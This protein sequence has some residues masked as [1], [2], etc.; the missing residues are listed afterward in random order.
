M[1]VSHILASLDYRQGGPPQVARN[2]G[3][4]MTP[5]GV[6]SSFWATGEPSDRLLLDPATECVNLFPVVWPRSWCRSPALAARLRL[7]LPQIDILHLHLFW[8]YPVWAAGRI[9]KTENRPFILTIHGLFAPWRLKRKALKKRLYLLFLGR[10]LLSSSS[11]VH[12][13]VRPEVEW[14]RAQ[15]FRGSVCLIPNGV[16][17]EEFRVLPDP[18]EAELEWPQLRGQ[19]MILFLSRISAE[20]GLDRLLPAVARLVKT[21]GFKDTMLVVAGPD[22]RGYRNS[23][24]TLVKELELRSHVL[25]TGPVAGRNKYRLLS[26][27]DVY[28]LPSHSEGFSISLLEA[29]AAGKPA[30]ATPGC[31]FPEVASAGAGLCVQPEPGALHDALAE[32]LGLSCEARAEMGC[33]GKSLVA[34]GYT[35]DA[36][37]AR[38]VTV[39]RCLKARTEVPLNPAPAALA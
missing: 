33:R 7:A 3:L 29:L 34:Q 9:A 11:C 27:A 22:D 5:Y 8:D 36:V 19:R 4:R 30:L 39:Y 10:R 18:R 21:E 28:A 12:A 15:G 23:V 2:L 20:K 37:A 26:R 6:R 16:N 1:N 32:L 35:W 25:L 13:I 24:E 17:L 31:N 38:M 14:I